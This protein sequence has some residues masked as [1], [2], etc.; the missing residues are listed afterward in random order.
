MIERRAAARF[1]TT[2]G[3]KLTKPLGVPGTCDCLLRVPFFPAHRFGR[4]SGMM[5]EPNSEE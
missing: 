4:L 1:A 2:K 5:T 3:T